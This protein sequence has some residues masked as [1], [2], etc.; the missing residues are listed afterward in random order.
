[1]DLRDIIESSVDGEQPM[2]LVPVVEHG[3]GSF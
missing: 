1:M 2:P 3:H